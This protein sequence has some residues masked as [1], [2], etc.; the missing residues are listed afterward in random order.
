[1]RAHSFSHLIIRQHDA[2]V[3]VVY[4]VPGAQQWK[5]IDGYEY[6]QESVSINAAAT[7]T[8]NL[9]VVVKALQSDDSAYTIIVDSPRSDSALE[10]L[11]AEAERAATTVK[12]SASHLPED[13]REILDNCRKITHAWHTLNEPAFE[14]ASM[15]QTGNILYT[16]GKIAG[17]NDIFLAAFALSARNADSAGAA[18][19]I[20]D[21]GYTELL[22][23][24][25]GAAEGHLATALRIWTG[26]NSK[27]GRLTALN[28]SGLLAWQTGEFS[29]ARK[30]YQESLHLVS[31]TDR[32]SRGIVL[33]NIGLI[34]RSM[35]DYQQAINSLE[36][37]LELL[38]QSDKAAQAKT[39]INLGRANLLSGNV[40]A[41]IKWLE[42]ARPLAQQSPDPHTIADV[43]NTL[44]QAHAEK[45]DFAE[46]E[47]QFRQAIPIHKAAGDQR[48]L[49]SSLHHLGLARFGEGDIPGSVILLNQAM[50]L[51]L[52]MG[53]RD[54]AA[55]TL[56]ALA[57]VSRAAG[58]LAGA[59]TYS[60][61]A[62]RII[63][64]VRSGIPGE[65]FRI[66]YFAG[67]QSFFEFY[68]DLLMDLHKARPRA[69]YDRE[70]FDVAEHARGRAMLELL[71]ETKENITKGVDPE[72]LLRERIARQTLGYLSGEMARL[73]ERS[74]AS[75]READ[76]RKRIEETVQ[77]YRNIEAE[78]RA[79]SPGYADLVWPQPQSIS[80]IQR[81]ALDDDTALLEYTLSKEHGHLWLVTR[82]SVQSFE[83]PGEEFLR[84][85]CNKMRNL[86]D[87]YRM[88]LRNPS[89]EGIYSEAAQLLSDL[90]IGPIVTRIGGKRLVI[91][92]PGVLQE[93][94][95]AA[96]S[97]SKSRGK[98]PLG[99]TNEMLRMTSASAFLE[100]LRARSRRLR[101]F[102]GVATFADPVFS[103]DDSRVPAPRRA[104]T[105]SS[106]L[107]RLPY[108][109]LEAEEVLQLFP[110]DLCLQALGFEASRKNLFRS[111]IGSFRYIHFGTHTIIQD[112]PE[113]SGIALSNVTREGNSVD[114]FISLADI[115]NLPALACD[116]VSLAGCDTG[117][118]R[119][120][121]GE[122]LLGLSRGFLYAGARSVLVSLWTLEE[123]PWTE[124]VMKTFYAELANRGLRPTAALRATRE[125]MWKRGGRWKDDYFLAG[126][127]LYGDSG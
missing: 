19:A 58:D 80:T 71:R 28:N 16:K 99:I 109:A 33:N 3:A 60:A 44:G 104:S 82:H 96:L 43:L 123:G 110:R 111:D 77:D 42:R 70:A 12:Q 81:E 21:A 7:T 18:E 29:I 41:S 26:M 22:L 25:L 54:D 5:E 100:G 59:R 50:N 117:T 107:A 92:A 56:F 78:I 127:E 47:S 62:L 68:V 65:H 84:P 105:P 34:F 106:G 69:G 61:R 102:R 39:M 88:R 121:R 6:G 114:G 95:F 9:K 108:S 30:R 87:N 38:P 113:L 90:L 52:S 118:G 112:V 94:P 53:L 101:P 97:I 72:L 11:R 31:K 46:A 8:V 125:L 45:H 64:S 32:R 66:G 120:I 86:A 57:R 85:L 124:E 126:L 27:Y 2:D 63:E 10:R 119:E 98:P 67:K 115:F 40:P 15:V 79:R 13:P 103:L 49:A 17:A 1:V 73:Q 24:Q 51:R 4:R 83:I 75:E 93:V 76:L 20:N 91:I 37:S 23:G 89:L 116:L 14:A 35:G 122:G 55:E 36:R 48:G 74:H